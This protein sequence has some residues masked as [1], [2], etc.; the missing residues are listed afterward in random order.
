MRRT[1]CWGLFALLLSTPLH[2]GTV[3][4]LAELSL[5]AE[6]NIAA[7]REDRPQAEEQFLHAGAGLVW[8]QALAT[9]LTLRLHGR[10]EGRVHARYDGLNEITAAGEAQG[11][12]QP[13]RGFHAPVIGLSLGGAAS[14]FQSRLRDGQE[15][16]LR[17]F[18]RERLTTRLNA[19][20]SLFSL[21]RQADSRVFDTHQQ[22]LE[23][24][25][26][27][28]ATEPL[29]VSVGYQFRDGDVVSVGQPNTVALQAARAAAP[30]DVFSGQTALRFA[31]HTQ[32]VSL[33]ANYALG[34]GLAWDSQLRFAQSDAQAF[35]ARYQRWS[36]VTGLLWRF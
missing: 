11:V 17:L 36:L 23:A 27:W 35:A 16:R 19:R 4:R 34:P 7:A 22:G 15:Y 18:L 9:A 13:G 12:W 14:A 26:D 10:A 31:A 2:A 3:T 33:G 24:A 8:S 5:G 1:L 29:S 28:Q 30:D 21:W 25:L 32:V 20:A 6:D